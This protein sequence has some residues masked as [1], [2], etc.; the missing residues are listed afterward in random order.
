M[1]AMARTHY[2][3]PL[4]SQQFSPVCWLACAV[5]VLQFK[6]RY[7]PSV[8]FLGQNA[9]FRIEGLTVED[10]HRGY[11]NQCGQLRRMGFIVVRSTNLR[12]PSMRA[13]A[14]P[15]SRQPIR[16]P[17][18]PSEAL[19]LSLLQDN[20]PFILI[21]RAGAFSYGPELPP[22]PAPAGGRAPLHAVVITGIDT[23]RHRVTFNNPWGQRDVATTSSSVVGAIRRLEAEDKAPFAYL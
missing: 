21:H 13:M 19:V 11:E 7:T 20:G 12:D 3:V 9:D 1:P 23:E 15:R 8:E 6:H 5:M 14:P 18:G 2:D 16:R 4:V 17:L 22:P 10:D